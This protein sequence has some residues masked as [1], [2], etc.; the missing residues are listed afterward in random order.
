MHWIPL[1]GCVRKIEDERDKTVSFLRGNP[2][3][4]V[5]QN[6]Y[7]MRYLGVESVCHLLK[8]KK[9]FLFAVGN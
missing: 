2:E 9:K 7:A 1:V 5:V 6:P 3:I 4:L 8:D